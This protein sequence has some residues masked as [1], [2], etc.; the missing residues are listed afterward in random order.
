MLRIAE[1]E[2]T[3]V[4]RKFQEID[5]SQPVTTIC[6]MSAPSLEDGGHTLG[7]TV[8]D[9]IAIQSDPELLMQ[10][11]GNLLDNALIHTPTGTRIDVLLERQT[12][13][14]VRI[15]VADTG[16]GI[17][18]GDRERVVRRFVTLDPG[19]SRPGHG[20]GL[21]LVAAVMKAHG[22]WF[23]LAD[24][25]PGLIAILILPATLVDT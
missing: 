24:N 25:A 10:A 11:L 7:W 19:R 8:P 12:D 22:G 2:G 20:L 17:T 23:R 16:P 14:S 1:V 3:A 5:L 21:N 15:C 4:A 9:G 18:E 13:R 6:E